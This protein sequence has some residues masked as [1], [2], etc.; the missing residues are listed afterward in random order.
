MTTKP[1]IPL[2]IEVALTILLNYLYA[3]EQKHYEEEQTTNHIFKSLCTV[4]E[5]IEWTP[6]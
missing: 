5:W 6:E 4:A 1:E 3:E 2:H